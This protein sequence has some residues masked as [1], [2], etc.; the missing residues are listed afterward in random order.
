MNIVY[1]GRKKTVKLAAENLL[2]PQPR[3]YVRKFDVLDVGSIFARCVAFHIA[4]PSPP[5]LVFV[6]V[7]RSCILR[8]QHII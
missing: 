1:F 8:V 7:F 3:I 4:S 5:T 6:A 2:Y